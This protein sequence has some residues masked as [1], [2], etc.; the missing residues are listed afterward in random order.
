MPVA[1]HFYTLKIDLIN[2]QSDGWLREKY[3]E[4][5]I[6]SYEFRISDLNK[7]PFHSDGSITLPIPKFDSKKLGLIPT[8]QTF[9]SPPTLHLMIVNMTR[10]DAM[11]V[12]NPNRDITEDRPYPE[13]Y[14]MKEYNTVLT[15]TKLVINLFDVA[16]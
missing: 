8:G 2:L 14:S 12:Y 5:V 13:D 7:S 6:A 3:K 16:I 15:R 9:S 10:I 4:L 1:N 11:I